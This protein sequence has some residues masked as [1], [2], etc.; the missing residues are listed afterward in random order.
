MTEAEWRKL[1]VQQSMVKHLAWAC[2][3]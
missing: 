2:D 1:G 3:H